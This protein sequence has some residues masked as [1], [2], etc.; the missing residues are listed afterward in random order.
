M[1][2]KITGS[3]PGVYFCKYS[4]WYHMLGVLSYFESLGKREKCIVVFAEEFMGKQTTPQIEFFARYAETVYI[5]SSLRDAVNFLVR[6]E[7]GLE[8]ITLITPGKRPMRTF[9]ALTRLGCKVKVVFS[10]EGLGT[11]GGLRQA[12]RA[13]ILEELRFFRIPRFLKF[14]VALMLVLAGDFYFLHKDTE[15][16]QL[17]DERLDLNIDVRSAYL[18][19]L[20]RLSLFWDDL[21]VLG[22]VDLVV[23][24]P[25]V[26]Y[27]LVE[28]DLFFL[29]LA[30]M[31][32][33]GD[34]SVLIKPHPL[35][36]EGKYADFNVV[37][38]S[39]PFE[40]LLYKLGGRIG[41]V[42]ATSSTC[43]YTANVIFGREVFRLKGLDLFYPF[44]SRK[45][46]A[47]VDRR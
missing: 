47:L 45:Q 15:N 21:L 3:N 12:I 43:C 33:S 14:A 40:M 23:T 29:E 26:E 10:E 46:K 41:R 11:Y 17:F 34:A 18:R 25:L 6:E 27:G 19:V 1:G 16:W 44:L 9:K 42:F 31:L 2:A 32:K 38:A 5:A 37:P 36:D 20:E 39:Y 24:P 30:P 7:P 4:S 13:C 22:E 8:S 28:S 35:E